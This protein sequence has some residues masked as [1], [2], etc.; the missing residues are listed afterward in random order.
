MSSSSG[1]AHAAIPAEPTSSSHFT[2]ANNRLNMTGAE[3]DAAGNVTHYNNRILYY[4]AEGRNSMAYSPSTGIESYSYD[5]DGRRV[6]KTSSIGGPV[7]VS[8]YFY[9]ALGQLAVEYSDQSPTSTGTSYLFTDMLGSVRT[10]TNDS[11]TVVENYDY[12][13]FGRML[14]SADNGRS[15]VGFFPPAP[16]TSV[17]SRTPHKFT[18]KERDAT[19]LDYFG[20]RYYSG[21]HG[22]FTSPDPV[23]MTVK[24]ISDPQQ[25]NLYVYAR[26]NPL[27]FI[28][29]TGEIIK[30]A[31][32]DAEHAFWEYYD[33][34]KKDPLKYKNE[35]AAHGQL[36]A[37]KIIYVV[38]IR[39]QRKGAEGS[40]TTDGDKVFVTVSNVGGPA[41]EIYSLNSRMGHELEHARQFDSGEIGFAKGPDGKWRP[42]PAS[43]DIGDEVKA[44]NV[45][46]NLATS[47]DY[48]TRKATPSILSQFSNAKSDDERAGVL[49]RTSYPHANRRMNSNVV[50]SE[51]SGYE[52]GQLLRTDKV[53]QR[54]HSIVK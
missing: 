38:G 26:N 36:I 43:Y 20:A 50:Y 47:G 17:G 33:F 2:A 9:D 1:L 6:K 34:I 16:D 25:I 44:W 35:L 15:A 28:D 46:L 27:I 52:P 49:V 19:G 42:N 7:T 45:Q 23:A 53:F 18:G 51:S 24:R 40:I 4:D 12:L 41:G 21:P 3:Y 14:S 39:N 54:V 30:F 31:S 11:G 22:R 5:G 37:S 32:E 10:I 13:P 29:P 8:Y 48:W